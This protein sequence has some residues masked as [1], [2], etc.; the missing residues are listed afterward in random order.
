M[1]E[2]RRALSAI[3]EFT[4]SSG[5]F[6]L[7]QTLDSGQ[8]FRWQRLAA[9]EYW[10]VVSNCALH[11]WQEEH[12]LRV[13][14][15]GGAAPVNFADFGCHYFDLSSDY[16]H[17]LQRLRRDKLFAQ[18]ASQRAGL[19]ILRQEPF[20]TLISFII[21]ANNHIP[22]IRS[23]IERVCKHYG[24]SINTPLGEA[25]SFPSPEALASARLEDLRLKCG[26]GY[27]DAYVQS[28]ARAI[29]A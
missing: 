13:R 5:E 28:V 1:A 11:L 16:Q 8:C 20:E 9:N 25:Y 27:R 10:G 7:E 24:L 21:S 22:R 6:D 26:L 3:H 23:I 14:H 12:R 17:I 15:W 18:L 19:R 2:E 4:F 29:A